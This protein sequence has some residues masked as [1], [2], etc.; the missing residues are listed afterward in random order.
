MDDS[1]LSFA[2]LKR[3]FA[4]NG[5]EQAR[6][7]R[8]ALGDAAIDRALGGGLARG[9]LHELVPAA[10]D[11]GPSAMGFAIMLA[12]RATPAALFWIGEDKA[13]RP[14]L[15]PPGLAELGADP[16]RFLFA[17]AAD[18]AGLLRAAADAVRSGAVGAVLLAPAGKAKLYDLTASRRLS[19]AAEGSGV[20]ILLLRVAGDDGPSA[21]A[22][23]WRIAAAPSRP[24]EAG[25]PG[26]P[27]FT[28]ELLRHRGG[29]TLPAWRLEWNR[30][31]AL[32][33]LAPPLSGDPSALPGDARLGGGWA[34]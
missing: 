10:E 13:G 4:R 20:T 25:A 26:Q 33:R 27:T 14:R 32:F 30:D 17:D 7:D 31:D 15:H 11:D 1:A 12:L 9:R 2:A 19:L 6:A 34:G 29:I 24:L 21:A 22:T 23:R 18:E 3:R 16:G 8:F 5:E 28:A